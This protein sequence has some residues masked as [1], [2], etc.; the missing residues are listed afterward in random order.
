MKELAPDGLCPSESVKCE[1][2]RLRIERKITSPL[3]LSFG[4]G[5]LAR[6]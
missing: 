6:K 1:I 4:P 3:S 5:Y 2:K